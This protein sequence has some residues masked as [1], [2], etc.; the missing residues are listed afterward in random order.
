M[1][2]RHA[3]LDDLDALTSVE[4]ACFPPQEAAD[5][6]C[7]A[8]R[9]EQFPQHFWLLINADPTA[10]ESCFPATVED[11]MLVSFIDGMTTNTADL[12]DVMYS[13]AQLH[14]EQGQWQMILGVN[15]A[16]VYQHCGCARYLM[17]RVI[18]DCA[19]SHRAGIVLTC[20]ER[21]IDFYTS[22]GFVDEGTSDSKHGN[23]AWHQMRLNLQQEQLNDIT[24]ANIRQAVD[25]A[26]SY[27]D[28][29]QTITGQFPVLRA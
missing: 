17:R 24:A 11:G 4:A 18:L 6:E 14:D 23:T 20:K 2:V 7:L 9:I 28:H 26:T 10:N 3:T 16:P 5:S 29:N 13:S 12:D 15:T 19:I 27:M 22:F 25:E 1:F 21:L 8:T